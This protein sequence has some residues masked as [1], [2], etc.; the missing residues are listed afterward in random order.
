M[1]DGKPAN[2]LDDLYTQATLEAVGHSGS[3]PNQRF[4]SGV[5]F[6]FFCTAPG[7]YRVTIPKV[8]GDAPI[9][10]FEVDLPAATIEKHVVELKRR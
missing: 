7:R 6:T 9:A 2:P 4:E 10:P 8:P 3:S 1:R 5:G